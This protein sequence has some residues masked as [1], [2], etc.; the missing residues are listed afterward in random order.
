MRQIISKIKVI[1]IIF[2]IK[3]KI[4]IFDSLRFIYAFF[5]ICV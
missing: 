1:L 3:R 5:M 2:W 4:M